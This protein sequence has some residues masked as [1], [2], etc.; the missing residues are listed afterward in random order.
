[1][2]TMFQDGGL[3]EHHMGLA[4]DI[5]LRDAAFFDEKDLESDTFKSFIR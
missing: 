2:E 5:F 3:D 1:M 4:L